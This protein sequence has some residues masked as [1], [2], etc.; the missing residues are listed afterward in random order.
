MKRLLRTLR[1]MLRSGRAEGGH[2][3]PHDHGDDIPVMLSSGGHVEEPTH[4]EAVPFVSGAVAD[5]CP[6]CSK[7]TLIR[8]DIYVLVSDGPHRIGEY[9]VCEECAYSP[10]QEDR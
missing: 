2:V 7:T 4:E 8:H 10:Y 3:V 1:A 5:W 6:R 9:A